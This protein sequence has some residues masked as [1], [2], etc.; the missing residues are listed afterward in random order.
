VGARGCCNISRCNKLCLS[1][2]QPFAFY[3]SRSSRLQRAI[4]LDVI[5]Y[6]AT[7]KLAHFDWLPRRCSSCNYRREATTVAEKQ[8]SPHGK[9]RK[10]VS[11]C[12]MGSGAST[13]HCRHVCM[14]EVINHAFRG[15]G[16]RWRW[17]SFVARHAAGSSRNTHVVSSNTPCMC[18]DT[19]CQSFGNKQHLAMSSPCAVSMGATRLQ[20]GPTGSCWNYSMRSLASSLSRSS[21]V[22]PSGPSPLEVR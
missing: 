21:L 1:C 22:A 5:Y 4:V 12:D 13:A 17:W 8:W 2:R 14:Q 3:A 6:L 19:C 16:L 20:L 10:L 9:L 15:G 7:C 18:I 11:L